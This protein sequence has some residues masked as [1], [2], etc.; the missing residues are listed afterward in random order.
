MAYEDLRPSKILTRGSFLNAIR[1]T[2]AI[3]GS[4]N[5]QPHIV[6]LARH[7]GID[8]TPTDWVEHGYPI[9]L[10]VNMQPAGKY[11][12]EQ[13]HRAGG[14]PSV[15]WELLQ[16]GKLDGKAMTVT[17]RT[18]AENVVGPGKL[19][20]RSYVSLRQALEGTMPVSSC[21]AEICS[22]SRS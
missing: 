10:L 7:A 19:R 11:L 5:A 12:S 20:P 13:F 9:P 6:A 17:G 4:S 14:V 22:T 18:Q 3:G 2:A 16:A 8:I 1:V 21:S 15:M